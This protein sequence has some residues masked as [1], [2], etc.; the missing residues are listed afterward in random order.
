MEGPRGLAR[1]G[2]NNRAGLR[3][4]LLS[5]PG[6]S[7]PL[8]H[9]PTPQ[10]STGRAHAHAHTHVHSSPGLSGGHSQPD[11]LILPILCFLCLSGQG[12]RFR[13][14]W[15][16]HG[17]S[18]GRSSP[19]SA[20]PSAPRHLL[21]LLGGR[22]GEQ[23]LSC[24][25]KGDNHPFIQPPGASEAAPSEALPDSAAPGPRASGYT[26]RGHLSIFI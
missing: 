11:R 8:L 3:G 13:C 6:P 24:L 25:K 7:R 23:R 19:A 1:C 15:G 26:G 2:R 21:L 12:V 22:A 17:D 9:L 20:Y 4:Q 18:A 14:T 10:A 16:K 5:T